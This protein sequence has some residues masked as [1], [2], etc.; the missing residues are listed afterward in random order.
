MKAIEDSGEHV[1]RDANA[2]VPYNDLR[3]GVGTLH[4]DAHR[5]ALGGELDRV[6]EQVLD[7]L[8]ET[9]RIAAHRHDALIEPN[10]EDD[11]LRFGNPTQ[12]RAYPSAAASASADPITMA[13]P[14]SMEGT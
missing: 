5:A 6:R 2:G 1:G 9:S 4:L 14:S 8:M 13:V 3:M 12:L 10:V 7:D 11:L